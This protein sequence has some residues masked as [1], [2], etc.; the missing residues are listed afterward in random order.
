MNLITGATGIVGAHVALRL[1][2]QNKP[3]VA[4]K[5]QGS[6]IAKTRKL[7]SYYTADA[8]QLF[9]KIRWLEADV[10]D[11]YSLLDA[12]EGIETVY[13]CAG[14]VSFNSKDN[15][16]MHRIN[17]EGT[18]NM[19]N[20]CLE[21]NVKA[22]CHVSSIATLQNPDIKT[23]IDESVYWKSSP[24]ASDYAISKYNGE[25]E[26]WRGSEEGLNV[27]IVNPGIILSPG[28]WTQSSGKLIQSC[29]KG[30]PF[31]TKGSS[32]TID[33]KDVADCMVKLTE[34]EQFNQRFVLI[35][36]NYSF[37]DILSSLHVAFGKKG[38][39]VEAGKITM[40]IGR[41]VDGISSRLSGKE[42]L[43]TKETIVAG[44]DQNSYSNERIKKTLNYQFT[45]LQDTVR[46]ICQSYLNDIKN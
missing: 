18:A 4:I 38:P 42:Q 11:I 26:V 25:R 36:N 33:A 19:V 37:K 17:S 34:S 22:L 7:F 44:L 45:S 9:Q 23:N 20:A 5:R 10:C 35:E 43:I 16:Q 39:N 28:F 1:L 6:D 40:M 46:F 27:V 29:Y 24:L 2:Q 8:E 41:C 15:K 32:A 21:K 3:V 30:N 13:H 12:L 31:Y 14:F